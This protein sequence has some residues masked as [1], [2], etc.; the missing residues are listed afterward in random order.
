MKNLKLKPALLLLFVLSLSAHAASEKHRPLP[1]GQPDE[2]EDGTK[3]GSKTLRSS[4]VT[5]DEILAEITNSKR[6]LLYDLSER[7]FLT[8]VHQ[9]N[10]ERKLTTGEGYT[11]VPKPEQYIFK[12]AEAFRRRLE[13][14]EIILI[15]DDGCPDS[16]NH[17]K[18]GSSATGHANQI[19][20]SLK[21]I[22]DKTSAQALESDA[23][24]II[25]HETAHKLAGKSEE[26]AEFAEKYTSG[27]RFTNMITSFQ[28]DLNE[29]E[30]KEIK[31]L[32]EELTSKDRHGKYGL[33]NRALNVTTYF[34]DARQLFSESPD[35]TTKEP[36]RGRFL[37][38]PL[39]N[40]R[41]RALNVALGIQ[42]KACLEA[43]EMPPYGMAFGNGEIEAMQAHCTKEYQNLVNE[44]KV[45]RIQN[46]ADF[47][48]EIQKLEKLTAELKAE[49]KRL[50]EQKFNVRKMTRAEYEKER[51]LDLQKKKDVEPDADAAAAAEGPAQ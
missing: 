40:L 34:L 50:Y 24:T 6:D 28:R 13:R 45:S 3:D 5:Q 22:S 31:R 36:S 42:Y 44:K 4:K 43:K 39:E 7:L 21:A 32:R 48:S 19:C 35:W 51:A 23:R 49:A 16:E 12:N 8:K 20:V 25:L 41:N 33:F 38:M 29:V 27:R 18:D 9:R 14:L 47:E 26:I 10:F 30:T 2:Y 37:P 1:F 11:P 46:D 17:P 15:T